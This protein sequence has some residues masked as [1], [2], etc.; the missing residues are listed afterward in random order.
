MIK[1]SM[2]LGNNAYAQ[3]DTALESRI[4][5]PEREGNDHPQG[6]ARIYGTITGNE[7]PASEYPA[8]NYVG[9]IAGAIVNI[10]DNGI[11]TIEKLH[12]VLPKLKLFFGDDG[13]L[14]YHTNVLPKEEFKN[15]IDNMII[16]GIKFN[17]EEFK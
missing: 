12:A 2:L 7:N 16:H 4:W 10:D 9:I 8:G 11:L 15:M 6:S 17:K 13:E 14:Y 5:D 3:A 1:D